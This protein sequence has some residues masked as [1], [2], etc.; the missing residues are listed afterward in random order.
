MGFSR[1]EYWSG[2]PLPSPIKHASLFQI[3]IL[4]HRSLRF[5]ILAGIGTDI[6][7][8]LRKGKDMSFPGLV[9]DRKVKN[10]ATDSVITSISRAIF[11]IR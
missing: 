9:K 8:M 3:A 5:Q 1:Q 4:N 7:K 2:V 6:A 10:Q 11:N